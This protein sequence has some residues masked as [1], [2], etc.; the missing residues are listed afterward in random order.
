[1]KSLARL[2]F[3]AFGAE[4]DGASCAEVSVIGMLLELGI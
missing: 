4:G 1:M 3:E 2:P